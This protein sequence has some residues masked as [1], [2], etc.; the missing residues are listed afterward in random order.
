MGGECNYLLRCVW[1]ECRLEFVPEQD[2]KSP[3]MLSWTP[4]GV[5]QLLLAATGVLLET[6]DHLRLPVKVCVC[7]WRGVHH[8]CLTMASLLKATCACA[9]HA[10]LPAMWYFLLV[11]VASCCVTK[12]SISGFPG[13]A[14]PSQHG[15]GLSMSVRA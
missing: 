3:Y 13:E 6:A 8:Q 2:W 12:V 4:Q 7:V 14:A 1:P 10:C 15:A 9:P 5:D 11:K